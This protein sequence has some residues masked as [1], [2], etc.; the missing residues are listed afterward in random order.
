ME[1]CRV[2]DCEAE[3]AGEPFA[4]ELVSESLPIS[5]GREDII[6]KDQNCSVEL[7]GRKQ[8]DGGGRQHLLYSDKVLEG[9]R[10]A[11]Q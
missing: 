10:A 2:R 6:G 3:A 5:K 1:A 7:K 4:I 8:Q 9:A 11:D